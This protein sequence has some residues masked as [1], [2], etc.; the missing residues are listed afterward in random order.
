MK[1]LNK[2]GSVYEEQYPYWSNKEFNEELLNLASRYRIKGYAKISTIEGLK[3][4]LVKNGPCYFACNVYNYGTWMWKPRQGD[5][6]LGGHAMCCLPETSIRTSEGTKTINNIEV[7][8]QVLTKNGW[9]PVKEVVSRKVDE[10]VYVV[11][12]QLSSEPLCVTKE[13]PIFVRPCSKRTKISLLDMSKFCFVNAEE[14]KEGWFVKTIIDDEIIDTDDVSMDFARLLGYYIGDG[15]IQ[16]RFSKNGNIKF[17]KFRLTYN[18]KDKKEIVED[19]IEIIKKEYPETNH[20]IYESKKCQTNII[21]FYNTKLAKKIM[22]YAGTAKNKK[23]NTTLMKLPQTK[24]EQIIYGWYKTDGCYEYLT[25]SS[26]FTSEKSLADSL[27]LLLQ[28]CRLTYS[29]QRR[30]AAINIIKEKPYQTKGGYRISFHVP[31]PKDRLYY[32]GNEIYT[33]IKNITKKS[34]KGLVYNFEVEKTKE[35]I[36]ENIVVHN[37]VVGYNEEGFIIRNSWGDDWGTDGYTVFPYDHWGLHR[38]IW[39]T[40]DAESGQPMPPKP[41]KPGFFKR[42]W[43]WIK[44][45]F[46]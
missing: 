30:A 42:I 3:K 45:L 20:S 36:A 7:G 38:E 18:R 41:K 26:I 5:V 24:Q 28:R 16:T 1:I 17:A 22:H 11:Y 15:N 19:L 39:T 12:S 9:E 29:V 44:G 14:V 4:A 32:K 37:C 31:Q 8:D 6:Q 40:I 35:Y 25:N 13:H 27:I 34:Y 43:N 2:I 33:R 46:S 10:E 21:T 23:L